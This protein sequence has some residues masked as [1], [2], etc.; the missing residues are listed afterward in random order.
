MC[1]YNEK[2]IDLVGLWCLTPLSTIF[3]LH[4]GCQFYWRRKLEY[5]EK[6]TDLTTLVVIGTGSC[7][8]NHHNTI[9]TMPLKKKKIETNLFQIIYV[10]LF[11]FIL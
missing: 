9:T 10:F 2:Y 3:Q 11:Q 7:N 5:P 1:N 4:R 8:S 6:T